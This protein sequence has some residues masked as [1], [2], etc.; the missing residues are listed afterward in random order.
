MRSGLSPEAEGLSSASG[1]IRD[2]LASRR[3]C[4]LRRYYAPCG[5]RASLLKMFRFVIYQQFRRC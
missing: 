2:R 5:T 1:G 3:P 4:A